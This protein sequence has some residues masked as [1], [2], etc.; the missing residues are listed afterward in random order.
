MSRHSFHLVLYCLRTSTLFLGGRGFRKSAWKGLQ[1]VAIFF[2]S[3]VSIRMFPREEV[4]RFLFS[5]E[6]DFRKM[7]AWPH[8][9][10]IGISNRTSFFCFPVFV[11]RFRLI[12][13]RRHT[14]VFTFKWSV[15]FHVLWGYIY[16][17]N[18]ENVRASCP[19]KMSVRIPGQP[20]NIFL[21]CKNKKCS[22]FIWE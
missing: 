7:K 19:R 3:T 15:V 20:S 1:N 10:I 13:W 12:K 11:F 17:E 14:V 8:S 4:L 5:Q 2:P 18:H 22:E 9:Y 6:R 21:S 16:K